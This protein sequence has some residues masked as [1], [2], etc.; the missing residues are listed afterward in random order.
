[1]GGLPPNAVW[2][3]LIGGPLDEDVRDVAVGAD[4]SV[5]VVGVFEGTVDFGT[6]PLTSAGAADMFLVRYA[7]DGTVVH[8][9]RYGDAGNDGPHAIAIDVAGDTIVAGGCTSAIDLGDGL[10]SCVGGAR[11]LAKI[12]ADGDLVWRLGMSLSFA[13]ATSLAIDGSGDIVMA[14][15]CDYD[16]DLGGGTLAGFI[17]SDVV[18]ARFT[19][20][21]THQ[22]SR[23]FVD[24]NPGQHPS[25]VVLG[26]SGSIH[27]A[28]WF[29]PN[30][31]DPTIDFGGG[32]L[33]AQGLDFLALDTFVATFDAAGEHVWSKAFGDPK[34]TAAAGMG[35]DASGD[36]LL[37]GTFTGTVDFGGGPLT[38]VGADV[39]AARLDA[40]GNHVWS[41][42]FAAPAGAYAVAFALSPGGAH[43]IGGRLLGTLDFGGGT[44]V[45]AADD[46]FV[47]SLDG[48]GQHLASRRFGDGCAQFVQQMAADP[49][50]NIVIAGRVEGAGSTIDLGNGPLANVGGTDIFVA[51]LPP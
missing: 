23:R 16:C 27:L 36:L 48:A 21:G 2:S 41:K 31:L 13:S 18:L 29:A 42:T 43:H 47:G 3:R 25:E 50:G 11:F 19:A 1:M 44:L 17:S 34:Y 6:G 49:S 35:C 8:A 46:A 7:P 22:W 24:H 15:T 45:A 38:A 10:E 40:S 5:V 39:F 14:G 20:S 12:E 33:V 32:P 30:V 51:K 26:P 9:R 4:G 28:G 37:G